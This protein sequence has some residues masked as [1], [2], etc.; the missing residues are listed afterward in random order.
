MSSHG[1]KDKIYHVRPPS[2]CNGLD[3]SLYGVYCAPSC[4]ESLWEK[5]HW[6]DRQSPMSLVPHAERCFISTQVR[7]IT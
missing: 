3:R 5:G 7:W 2:K 6:G 1:D 4:L